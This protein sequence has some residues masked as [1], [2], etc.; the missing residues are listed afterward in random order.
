MQG[1]TESM[2]SGRAAILQLLPFSIE[3]TAKVNMLTVVSQRVLARPKS[4]ALWFL[5]TFKPIWKETSGNPNVRDLVT[6]RRFLAL[7]ASRHDQTLN[8]T[9]LA[10][11]LGV[12][13]PTISSGCTFSKSRA[14]SSLFRRTSKTL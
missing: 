7:L 10:A 8:K 2:K 3:E 5:P 12:S 6:F 14:K 11:P 13:V 4:R 9:D 1:I